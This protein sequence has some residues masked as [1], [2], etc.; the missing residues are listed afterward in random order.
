[1]PRFA[2]SK[3][4]V[5]VKKTIAATVIVLTATACG[6]PETNAS[7]GG[8]A[9]NGAV[10]TAKKPAGYGAC[11]DAYFKSLLF[12]CSS[13]AECGGVLSCT[14]PSNCP[15]DCGNRCRGMPCSMASPVSSCSGYQHVC[16]QTAGEPF[17][18][19]CF[20]AN[21]YDEPQCEIASGVAPACTDVSHSG[22]GC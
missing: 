21:T 12:S 22:P 2:L 20:Q 10:P 19:Q 3:F 6:A 11:H 9:D 17:Y 14:T 18:F 5:T 15:V 4:L 8:S 7:M 16:D 13:D 1:M